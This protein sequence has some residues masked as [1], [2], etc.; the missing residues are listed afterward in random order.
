ML[1]FGFLAVGLAVWQLQTIK[2]LYFENQL[3]ELGLIINAV[4]LFLFLA[5]IIKIVILL[6]GYSREES[7]IERFLK[8]ASKDPENPLKGVSTKSLI[9]QR[10][11][12]MQRLYESRT[13]INNGA[14]TSTLL[15]NE[16]TK[17][18]L[19]RFINNVLILTGV[20][21]T[22][23]SLS[24]ALVGASDMLE[25]AVESGGMGMVIHG[26]STAL[27]TTM[28]AIA[29]YIFFG[30]FYFKL[31]DAQTNLVSAIEEVTTVYL[32]P[33]FQ[34]TNDNVIYEVTGLLRM[35]QQLVKKMDNSQ[36]QFGKMETAMAHAIG[37]FHKQSEILPEQLAELKAILREG[38]RLEDHQEGGE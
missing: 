8:N 21:G 3:L 23:V 13:P 38:F 17:G 34:V 19:P 26:M 11:M 18:S 24:I 37:N 33:K 7:G 30:Y 14:L 16:S 9:A 22:I 36:E 31:T 29:C 1:F 5:G 15:A 4:I 28:T 25:N 6:M 27:S 35:L 2:S 20:F 32:T 12:T 10:F